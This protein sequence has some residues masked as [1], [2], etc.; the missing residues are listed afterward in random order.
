[1]S[2]YC[3]ECGCYI[4]DY[5]D[6]CPAC[7]RALYVMRPEPSAIRDTGRLRG[8]T[9][10]DTY[11]RVKGNGD[12]EDKSLQIKKLYVKRYDYPDGYVGSE[13]WSNLIEQ[14]LKAKAR[15]DALQ[16][17]VNYIEDNSRR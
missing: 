2:K 3:R 9:L 7:H 4:P 13:S 16:E 10:Y 5:W 12:L 1:M 14:I 17:L 8:K 6:R 11:N 15:T